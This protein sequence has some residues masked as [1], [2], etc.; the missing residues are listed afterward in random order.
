MVS[1]FV[2]VENLMNLQ[3]CNDWVI[4]C[5]AFVVSGNLE[6]FDVV[7]CACGKKAWMCVSLWFF[8][9]IVQLE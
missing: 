9:H 2:S 3:A 6:S 8:I 7:V 1:A 4:R 5:I